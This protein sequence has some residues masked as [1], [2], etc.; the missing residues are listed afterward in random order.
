MGSFANALFRI[1]LG[2]LQGVVSA[3]WSAFNSTDGQSFFIWIGKH[4]ITVAVILC[5]TGL[6]ADLC[7]YILR[8]K[9]FRVWKSFLTKNRHN[10][11]EAEHKED[12]N[13]EEEDYPQLNRQ[14]TESETVTQ[15]E[16]S[17]GLKTPDLS[18]WEE[19]LP[20]EVD[21]EVITE[22]VRPVTVTNAGYYV[23]EDSPYRRP[24]ND[25]IRQ[26]LSE[27]GS[28]REETAV[29]GRM[30][31]EKAVSPR[32]RRRVRVTELFTDPEEELKTVDAPQHL[33]DSSKAY[34]TPV[35]PQGWKKNEDSRE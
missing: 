3:V 27:T 5:I 28:V 10:A 11:T 25:R 1:L 33:I 29:S 26:C 4:W 13:D 6:A 7:V 18:Q 35:Y 30:K 16:R 22:K 12:R 9:P 15:P 19:V 2:W 8:W 14:K 31:S 34:R 24:S 17:P 32:R 20:A 21:S 23:P